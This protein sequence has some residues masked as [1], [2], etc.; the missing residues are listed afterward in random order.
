MDSRWIFF[1]SLLIL[2]ALLSLAIAILLTR[3]RPADGRNEMALALF[4]LA[5]W[6]FCY[7][8]ITLSPSLETKYVWLKLEN[9]GI[10]SQPVF[11]FLFTVNYTRAMKPVNRVLWAALWI[12]PVT[13]LTLLFSSKWIPL[14][15]AATQLA[16]ANGGPLVITRGPWY[17]PQLVQTYLLYI[18]S[19]VI[20]LRWFFKNHRVYRRRLGLLVV[21][22]LAPW[23]ANLL[24]QAALT[25]HPSLVL[26]V[27]FTPIWATISS[28]LIGAVVFGFRLFDL[29]P[30]ARDVVMEHI[31]ELMVVV[32][33]HDRVLDANDVAL[34]WLGKTEREIIGQDPLDVFRAW[35]QLVSRFLLTHETHEEIQVGNPPRTLEL[36]VTPM[37]N[38]AEVLQ[39][40]VIVA[41]DVTDRKIL[42]DSLKQANTSLRTQLAEI[43]SLRAMLQEQ[44]I[45]DPLTGAFNRRF[46]AETLDKEVMRAVRESKPISV[47][48][49]DLDFFKRFNDTYGH[50]CGDVI[51]QALA[52]FLT[53][54][55]R[56]GD[57]LC[58]YGGEEFVILMPATA[59]EVALERAEVLRAR[60]EVLVTEYR[61]QL[62]SATFSAGVAGYPAHGADGDSILFA[63]DQALY[64]SKRDGRNRVSLHQSGTITKNSILESL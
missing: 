52:N 6:A 47:I 38:A 10:V 13:S 63:A 26:P 45:R 50:K 35:P 53:Q 15:Y 28:V 56:G 9:I 29:L 64:Q 39:G 60:Y 43:E 32:D 55:I 18:V 54:N 23:L 3:T 21:A 62:L 57:I 12:I 41:H 24:Y 16:A 1:A 8:M 58:R 17:W 2:N 48:I 30:I 20:L 49:L 22:V 27:D 33:A 42:E 11:W 4:M 34:Q 61:G 7:G 25:F 5:V 19:T 40:R 59:P 51:L 37:Y 31:P 36:I 46:F 14:Y 44:A